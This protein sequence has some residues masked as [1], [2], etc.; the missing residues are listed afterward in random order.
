MPQN[1]AQPQK[2]S[3]ISN[4]EWALVIGA[5][6][7]IDIIQIILDFFLIGEWINWLIDL[8]VGMSLG[9]Y[10]NLRGVKLDAKKLITLITSLLIEETSLGAAPCWGIDVCMTM[11]WDKADKN[12]AKIPVV[13]KVVDRIEKNA[14]RA[15]PALG[16]IQGG[17]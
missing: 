14:A 4:T 3:R 5:A 13:G 8:F 17:K 11:A 1:R 2:G 15:A 16:V 9:F 7:A 12:L 10:Y 6:F